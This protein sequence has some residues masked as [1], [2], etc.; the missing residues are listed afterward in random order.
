[1]KRNAYSVLRNAY[2]VFLTQYGIRFT[3]FPPLTTNSMKATIISIG[4]E[5]LNGKTVNSNAAY[6]AAKL[7]EIGIVTGRIVAI[8]DE[9]AAILESLEQALAQSE[10]VITTG[11]LGPTPD[12][13]TK[14]ALANFFHSEMVFN[15]AIWQK[16]EQRF[17][18]RGI[19]APEVNR[20]QAWIPEKARLI[21][22]PI[23]SAPGLHFETPSPGGIAAAAGGAAKHTFVLPGVPQEMKAIVAES[24]IPFLR[25]KNAA[26]L[27]E[28]R[29]YRTTGVAESKIYELCRALLESRPEYEVAFLPKTTGVDLRVALREKDAAKKQRFAEFETGLFQ[30]IGK[31]IYT[32]GPKELEE[33]V[34]KLLRERRLTLAAAESCTG[35]LVQDKITDIAGSSDYFIGGMV[36]YSNE[37]KMRHLGVR[38]ESLQ[39]YGAVSEAVAR[40][41]AEGVRRAFGADL[42]I[43][44]T[45][46]AGPGGATPEKPL[47]LIYL[48]LATAQKTAAKKF[49][50]IGDRVMIKERGAQAALELLRRELLGME[51]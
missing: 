24:V 43:S 41:M 46:I 40:E 1:M 31:Y 23:G 28:V 48:G 11:G 4:N 3:F 26:G 21:D 39:R 13:I 42:G 5:L 8:R 16:I 35:G 27:I 7:Y 15:E 20:V 6:I 25:Q 19:P 14:N 17:R 9:T 38:A 22:N 10:V 47:G 49:L 45:G 32:T 30:T 37:S 36:A 34:G 51:N 33:V 50:L 12:D 2:S 29:L 18:Q 44:T